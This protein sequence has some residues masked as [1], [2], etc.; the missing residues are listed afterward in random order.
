M[1]L[2]RFLDTGGGTR[3]NTLVQSENPT[4]LLGA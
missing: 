3:R 1:P 4:L 2:M